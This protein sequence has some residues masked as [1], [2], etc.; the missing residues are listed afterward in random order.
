MS[1]DAGDRNL[2][3]FK[4]DEEGGGAAV[5]KKIKQAYLEYKVRND[6]H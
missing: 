2:H 1:S 6:I 5:M 3:D 4:I